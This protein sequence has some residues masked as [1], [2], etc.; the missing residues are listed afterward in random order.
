M[1]KPSSTDSEYYFIIILQEII[2]NDINQTKEKNKI[3]SIE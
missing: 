2:K 1:Y 3:K